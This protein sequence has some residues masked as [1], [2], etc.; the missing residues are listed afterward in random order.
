MNSCISALVV[1]LGNFDRP[2]TRHSVGMQIVDRLAAHFGAKWSKSREAQSYVARKTLTLFPT[3]SRFEIIFMK[4]VFPMNANGKS[5]R[6]AV[7]HFGISPG[8]V[9]VIH[10]ELDKPVGKFGIKLNG[11]ARG[12]NGVRSVISSL[13]SDAFVRLRIGI[14]RPDAKTD[15]S[16][17]VLGEFTDH[18][19]ELVSTNACRASM[20]LLQTIESQLNLKSSELVS[21]LI[22]PEDLIGRE[23]DITG[24]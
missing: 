24:T 13:S 10:D 22:N 11:S 6:K 5:V 19:A 16:E 4:S 3:G 15:V 23:K 14:G 7:D 9:F 2:T 21:C 8:N 12:H 17:Y 20:L 1:G 18:E